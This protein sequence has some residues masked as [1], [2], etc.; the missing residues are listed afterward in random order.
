MKWMLRINSLRNHSENYP[1]WYQRFASLPGDQNLTLRRKIP[2][3]LRQ[4]VTIQVKK[5][6]CLNV[7]QQV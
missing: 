7:R 1:P 4:T 2:L 5:I 3:S 6:H